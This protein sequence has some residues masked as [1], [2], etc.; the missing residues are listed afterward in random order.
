MRSSAPGGLLVGGAANM[1]GGR[2]GKEGFRESFEKRRGE[3]TA[4]GSCRS[5]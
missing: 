3:N 1:L 4:I 5:D 2:V